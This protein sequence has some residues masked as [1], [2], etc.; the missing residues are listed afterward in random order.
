M[1]ACTIIV[2][3]MPRQDA[4][5]ETENVLPSSNMILNVLMTCHVTLKRF[6]VRN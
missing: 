3:K 2:G 5:R 6:C 1:A 4:V